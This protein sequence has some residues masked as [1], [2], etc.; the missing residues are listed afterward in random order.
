MQTFIY[1]RNLVR[2]ILSLVYSLFFLAAANA[3][4]CYKAIAGP[5]VVVGGLSG[6]GICASQICLGENY[7]NLQF[8]VDNDLNTYADWGGL[9]TLL[10]F[11]GISVKNPVSYPAGYVAGFVFSKTG[12]ASLSLF[13]DVTVSTWLNGTEQEVKSIN[14]LVAGNLVGGEQKFY[15]TFITT[16]PFDEVRLNTG[17]LSVSLLSGFKVFGAVAFPQDC[18]IEDNEICDDFV[19]GPG[20]DVTYSGTF[21]CALCN[22]EDNG[23]EL[24]DASKNNFS[25]LTLPVGV[26]TSASVGVLD[27]RNVY[28]AGNRAGFVIAPPTG[29]SLLSLDVLNGITIQTYLFGQLQDEAS[30]DGTN[31]GLLNIG[32]LNSSGSTLKQKIGIITSKP[33]N[34]VRIVFNIPAAANL[35]SIRL[36][37]AFEEPAECND[38]KI[39]L[40]SEKTGKHNGSLQTG[41]MPGFLA[42]PW[43]GTYGIAI[44]SLVNSGNVVNPLIDDY[45]VYNTPTILGVAAGARVTVKNDGTLFPIGTFAGFNISDEGSWIDAGLLSAITIKVYNNNTLVDEST[46][47]SLLGGA[48][49]G[50]GSSKTTV[51]FYPDG[52]FNRIQIDVNAGLISAGLFGA[53]HIFD[54]FVIEDADGDSV[55][56]CIDQCPAGDDTIDTDGDGVPDC[57]EPAF[58]DIVT[59]KKLVNASQT[60]FVPGDAVQY[61]ITVTNNGPAAASAVQVV[62]NAPAG[63]SIS[64]WTAAGTGVTPPATSG[65]GNLSET[66]AVLPDGASVVY[67]ITLQTEAT[68]AADNLINIV[69]VTSSTPDPDPVCPGCMTPGLPALKF[70]DLTPNIVI[71]QSTI[72]NGESTNVVVRIQ[73]LSSAPTTD[74]I[75]FAIP[76][77]AP[78]FDL[79]FSPALTSISVLGTSWNVS[80]GDVNLSMVE[81]PLRYVFTI[82]SGTA[83]PGGAIYDIGLKITATGVTTSTG[84]LLVNIAQGTGGGERP[85]EN[86]TR[87][88]GLAIN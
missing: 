12:L 46:A 51:G 11:Q 53:Y 67:T 39:S 16:Q 2:T 28:P 80:N 33:F 47:S 56:D 60:S 71:G 13:N 61:T 19:S 37:G 76:K 1:R 49:F 84:S 62:D 81:Q 40:T 36:Y 88:V 35:G 7:G 14:N 17:V 30:P 70:A 79:E 75:V 52:A 18:N 65:T 82:A 43:T 69:E 6:T 87:V 85:T 3:Q 72:G 78:Q 74:A 29:N 10:N 64:A 31:S 83:I 73:N 55:P 4:D 44:Q 45:A 59:E 34:E 50:G 63:T 58:A 8:A 68:Y 21:T 23:L 41:D 22:L 32:L 77:L 38:C 57:A 5:G 9:A 26:L 20:T 86:N 25:D 15:A 27:R 42:G 48:L 66:I 24:T 54:A